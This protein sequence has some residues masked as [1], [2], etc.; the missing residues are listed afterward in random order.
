MPATLPLVALAREP[1]LQLYLDADGP[2]PH[3]FFLDIP[4]AHVQVLIRCG[5]ASIELQGIV[6][7]RSDR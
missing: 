6:D 5:M 1:G 7:G 3:S 4:A 2:V